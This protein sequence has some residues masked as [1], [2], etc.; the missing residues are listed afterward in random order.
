MSTA[1]TAIGRRFWALAS[2]GAAALAAIVFGP[3]LRGDFVWDDATLIRD[4]KDLVEPGH[5]GHLI[6]SP[7]EPGAS[8]Y[9]PLSMATFW[10]QTR[11]GGPSVPAY[12][13]VNIA[14]HAG[15]AVALLALLLRLGIG[16]P[17]AI[18]GAALFLL[19]PSATEP[20][21]WLDGRHDT[22]GALF[23]IGALLLWIPRAE[24]S[25]TRKREPLAL[26]LLALALLCK[27]VFVVVPALFALD[28]LRRSVEAKAR[29]ANERLGWLAGSFGVV[30]AYFAL[31]SALAIPSTPLAG[32]STDAWGTVIGHYVLQL[33]GGAS[34]AT[35][36]TFTLF[37]AARIDF[38]LF[39]CTAAIAALY[40]LF[41]RGSAPAGRA[42]LGV[43]WFA[44][45]L[46]PASLAIAVAEQ[47]GNRYAY[48]PSAGLAIALAAGLD[49]GLAMIA[50]HPARRALV[51]GA[52]V[53]A[54]LLAVRASSEAK[55]F[56]DEASLFG[57]S[58]ARLP[59]DGR[60]LFHLAVDQQRREGCAAAL[61]S[62]QRAAE[63][64]P[65]YVRAWH[66]LAGCLLRERR[67]A[68]AVEPARRAA[69]LDPNNPRRH[70]NVGLALAGSGD[71]RGARASLERALALDPGFVPAQKALAEVL[72]RSAPKP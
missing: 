68:D 60:A 50:S 53:A 61:P 59:G 33:L 1:V 67:F 52:G 16:A 30:A 4:N 45:A 62:F 37:S 10:L 40:A 43:A 15:T 25:V 24:E 21:M 44:I 65:T 18:L 42:A 49:R 70:L 5:L 35:V 28:E 41:Q 23:A 63:L 51:G 32:F 2:A 57:A 31:R 12:R 19:H 26:L 54:T 58:V 34:G 66:N 27:E 39:L 9:R 46:A 38:A 7:I 47:Y 55:L 3:H 14:I 6:T 69:A 22:L 20:V 72:A 11:L 17:A 56:H 71:L 48:F 64:A 8:I 36:E 13:A 29:P